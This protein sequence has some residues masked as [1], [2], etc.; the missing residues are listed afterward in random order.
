M[1]ASRAGAAGAV[2]STS[3]QV[4][5]SLGAVVTGAISVGALGG[6]P[7][8]EGFAGASHPAWLVLTACGAL[9]LVLGLVTTTPWA[10]RTAHR[11]A[12]R[13]GLEDLQAPRAQLSGPPAP[14]GRPAT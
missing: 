6:G 3:R 13:F 9:I 14:S 4:G 8:E 11:T 1:P 12:E 2:A 10:H 7:L 5:Q